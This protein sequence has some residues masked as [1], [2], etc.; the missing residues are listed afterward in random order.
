MAQ[1]PEAVAAKVTE[2]KGR[3]ATASIV[4][5]AN[6]PW[7]VAAESGAASEK[8]PAVMERDSASRAAIV[9]A[10]RKIAELLSAEIATYLSAAS[11]D[12]GHR[13]VSRE[14][15]VAVTG[16][17]LAR[18]QMVE[19]RYDP[20]TKRCR[21]VVAIAPQNKSVGH[22]LEFA[23]AEQAA[24]HYLDRCSQCL[25]SPGVICARLA[26]GNDQSPRLVF[27]AI[28]LGPEAPDGRRTVANAKAQASLARFWG[29]KLE[30]RVQL[31]QGRLADPDDPRGSQLI[32]YEQLAKWATSRSSAVLPPFQ[33]LGVDRDGISFVAIWCTN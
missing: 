17:A 27:I 32:H 16:Q 7:L 22:E 12:S 31:E 21:V 28:A 9:A 23:D 26:G 33:S 11:D 13:T 5:T 3:A 24:R 18:V 30:S 29:E 19:E 1:L 2:L 14:V 8:V 4:R 25:A 6:G 20:G 15:V 10:K